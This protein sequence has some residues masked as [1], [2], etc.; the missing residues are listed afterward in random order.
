MNK[1]R[2]LVALMS[3][4]ACNFALAAPGGAPPPPPTKHAAEPAPVLISAEPPPTPEAKVVTYGEK[5]VIV[6]KTKV[7]YTTL[8]VLPKGEQILDFTCGDK[9]FWI[10]NGNE[11]F[12][13]VKPAKT[14]AQTNLN[15]VTASG[16]IYSFELSEISD[17]PH[18]EPDL[19]LF[20]E[21]KDDGLLAATRSAPR[22]VSSQEVQQY[23]DDAAKAREDAR[24]A[25]EATQNAVDKGIQQ[26][27][28]NV[29]FPY[30]FEAGKKPFSVRAMYHDDR[31]TYIQA[32]PE[33]TPTLY[34][35]KDGQPSLVNFTYK[36]GVYVVEKILDEGYLAIGKQKL[37]F[38]R[39]E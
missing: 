3:V 36:D 19:K 29:R 23:K 30:R 8:I 10:V 31:F 38:K 21:L 17:V 24:L 26:F 15:L 16:N 27:V 14:G 1:K 25:K 33:E 35:V 6:V 34:E 28:S 12:A 7:R 13:Y 39:E 37:N 9:E 5:D 11:N 18:E 22:F 2:C 20:V 4:A 32:R